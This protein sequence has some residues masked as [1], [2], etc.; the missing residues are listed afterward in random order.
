MPGEPSTIAGSDP[1]PFDEDEGDELPQ[2]ASATAA[3]SAAV[4][5]AGVRG[6]NHSRAMFA[7][8]P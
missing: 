4:T 8:P 3:R 7:F 5:D 2:P 6:E 1:P